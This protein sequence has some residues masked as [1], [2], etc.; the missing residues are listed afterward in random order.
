MPDAPTTMPPGERHSALGARLA[1]AALGLLEAGLLL[2]LAFALAGFARY[3][4]QVISYP[5]PLDYGEGPILDQVMRLAR[6]Q[7]IYRPDLSRPPYVVTNYPPLYHL[8]QVPA[9]WAFGPA[10]W[11][12]RALSLLG[13]LG[14]AA[15]AGWVV[16]TLTRDRLA[17]VTAGCTLLAIPYVLTWAP[18]CRVDSLALGLSLS[19]LALTVR[20]PRARWSVVGTGLLL[21]A[22]V[23]TRQS[24]GL[25][26]PLAAFAWFWGQGLRRRALALAGLVG[27][28][29][30]ALFGLL[31]LLTGGGFF[32]HL[33][34]ANV[35]AFQVET[36]LLFV[37]R[38]AATLP[39][40]L[41]LGALFGLVGAGFRP[42]SWWLVAPYTLGGLATALTIGKI[43]SNVNYLLEL[44]AALAL[45]AGVALASV[46]RLRSEAARP[47]TR[48]LWRGASACLTVLLVGQTVLLM[49]PPWSYAPYIL[50][51][52]RQVSQAE[53]LLE[54][55][56]TTEGPVLADDHMGLLV[57]AG[58]SLY[59]QPFE[60]KQLADA[61][62]WDPTPFIQSLE[63]Q[64]ISLILMNATPVLQKRR[65]TPAMLRAIDLHYSAFKVVGNTWLYRPR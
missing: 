52:T 5:Y 38:V 58:R 64:E 6:F 47:A 35:N 62:V 55:I 27:G 22:A 10:F 51:G 2:A 63:H 49:R 29:G 30:L 37:R 40:L 36:L 56:R 60:T 23:Y 34:V 17:S 3:A 45:V 43:G 15:S 39:V 19:A 13:A 41:A 57:L 28:G 53:E 59:H 54:V 14:A 65:W 48:A 12:G 26:A 8:L 4:W 61:G 31:N 18:L 44:S 42:P 25:A 21:L 32:F 50:A 9:A 16:H 11:Y 24:Y 33:V 1:R 20:W 7:T 46:R